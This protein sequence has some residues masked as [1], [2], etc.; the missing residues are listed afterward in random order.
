MKNQEL[1][2]KT[3]EF[4]KQKF[5][6]EGTGHDW[7]H[8]YRVQRLAK[9]IAA[10]EKGADMLVVELG[11]L[12]HDIA[13]HKFHGGDMEIGPTEAG[14]WLKKL[15]ADTKT[16]EHVQDIVRNIST[17][18]F[19]DQPKNNLKTLEGQIVHDADKL[20]A[21]GAIGI[22]RLFTLSGAMGRPMHVPDPPPESEYDEM[23]KRWG[24]SS[25]QHF[26]DKLLHLKDR[27][28]TETGKQLAQH[29][30]EVLEQYLN[31]F[32]SEWDGKL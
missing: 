23:T 10:K 7:W 21:L 9:H 25:I 6:N 24:I 26:Y 2:D 8:I 22:G 12:L 13:D 31:E 28:F 18:K 30:H 27:M 29:R 1:I 4:I 11:A 19:K 15:G 3:A 16:I 32:Y 14:K 20:D 17:K 5:E